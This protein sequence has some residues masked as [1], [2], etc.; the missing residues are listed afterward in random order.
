MN[1][2]TCIVYLIRAGKFK[3]NEYFGPVLCYRA[4]NYP[5]IKLSYERY[6]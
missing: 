2:I 6:S 3:K 4:I 5:E 1:L